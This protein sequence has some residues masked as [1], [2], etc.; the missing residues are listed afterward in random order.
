ML[1]FNV[2]LFITP[3]KIYDSSTN[4]KIKIKAPTRND[5]LELWEGS[6]SVSDIPVYIKNLIKKTLPTNPS[7]HIC[8]NRFKIKDEYK[9]ELKHLK[10][11]TIW[12]DKKLIQKTKNGENVPSLE[13]VQ[14]V[15]AQWNLINIQ[16]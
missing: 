9:L 1:L 15:L 11:E 3:G 2:F 7:I 10:P 12:C 8:L 13:E 6:Y 4:N 14:V 5:G 16:Y